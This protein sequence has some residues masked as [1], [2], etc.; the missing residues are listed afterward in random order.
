MSIVG[1]YKYEN[2]VPVATC[3]LSESEQ[4]AF[5]EFYKD[6]LEEKESRFTIEV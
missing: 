4:E 6:F 5:D 3:E 1:K 2:G